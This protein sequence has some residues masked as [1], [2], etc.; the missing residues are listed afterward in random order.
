MTFPMETVQVQ[1]VNAWWEEIIPVAAL[2]ISLF[3]VALTLVYR[4]F[5]RLNLSVTAEWMPV[6]TSGV[7]PFTGLDRITVEV[8]NR[9][10]SATTEVTVLALQSSEKK[11]FGAA[12]RP[13]RFDSDLPIS[14]GPGQSASRSYPAQY[15]GDM[16][17]NDARGVQWVQAMAVS[18]HKTVRG[19][20]HRALVQ[21]LRDYA[22]E[23]P[24]LTR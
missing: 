15:V 6:L 11:A 18:G 17:N 5:D 2:V 23:H 10:R 16:L 19:R 12:G 3:S 21:K 20:R 4:Y 7:Q 1:L 24:V 13:W 14:L 8:T 9:S 22:S